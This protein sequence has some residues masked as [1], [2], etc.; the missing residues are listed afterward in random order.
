MGKIGIDG[1]SD[2]PAFPIVIDRQ[3]EHWLAE[4][5]TIANDTQRACLF[6]DENSPIGQ[7]FHRG[8]AGE[9]GGAGADLKAGG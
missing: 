3:L 2:Q 7:R 6:A 4:Q 5:L 1:N 8:A 9:A